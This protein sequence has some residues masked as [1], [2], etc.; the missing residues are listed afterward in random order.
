MFELQTHLPPAAVILPTVLLPFDCP[1][2]P[3]SLGHD[4][5]DLSGVQTGDSRQSFLSG[6]GNLGN[7]VIAG[8]DKAPGQDFPNPVKLSQ[9]VQVFF[10]NGLP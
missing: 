1:R 4:Q 9:F 8:F 3:S 10:H 7:A 5:A 6:A 2:L